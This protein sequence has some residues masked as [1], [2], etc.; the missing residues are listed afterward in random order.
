MTTP[1]NN[2]ALEACPHMNFKADVAVGRLSEKDGGPITHYC[3][4]ITVKCAECGEPFEFIGLPMGHSAYRPTVSIDGLELRQPL[5]PKG[6]KPPEGLI[7]F[8]VNMQ[9]ATHGKH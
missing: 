3:A 6:K 8:S 1:H 4:D 2:E 9:D 5:M 7:G